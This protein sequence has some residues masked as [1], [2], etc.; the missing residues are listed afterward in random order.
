MRCNYRERKYYCG[1]YLEVDI[2][3]VFKQQ[4]GRR[5]KYKPTSEMQAKLNE[6]NSIRQLTRLLNTNFKNGDIAIHLTY[7]DE[8]LPKTTEEALKTA[9]NYI[10]RVKRYR[11]SHGLEPL[12]FVLVPAGGVNESR[13][14]FHMVMNA[15]IDR[16]LLEDMWKYGYAH[17]RKLQFT[18]NGVEGLAQ[19]MGRQFKTEQGKSPFKKRWSASRN[20][21]NPKPHDRDGRISQRRINEIAA[22]E[23]EPREIFEQ[24]YEGYC[25]SQAT[26][27]F[28]ETNVG[29]YLC[30]RMYKRTAV[31]HEQTVIPKKIVS[32]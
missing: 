25:Y 6:K 23:V 20:L 16:S 17:S 7:C 29:Y 30:V 13:Y 4:K 26:C 19:Y 27:F 5:G 12:K 22:L 18:E 3:P 8:Y 21:I 31:S 32:R 11:A 9:Q 2:Y 15:G 14:H 1:N 28:N 10:R 24:L